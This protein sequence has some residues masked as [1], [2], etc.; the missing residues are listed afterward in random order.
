MK[1]LIS[2][3]VA[4]AVNLVALNSFAVSAIAYNSSTG[5]I[6]YSWGEA[7][8]SAAV[9]AAISAC[10]YGCRW[11]AWSDSCVAIAT[12]PNGAYGYSW[13]WSNWGSAVSAAIDSCNSNGDGPCSW[14]AW[15][16]N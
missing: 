16:C 3:L 4:A 12:G 1:K 6:G 8:S 5:K 13:N 9:D 2:L 14:R 7:N 10:G 15:A 11:L